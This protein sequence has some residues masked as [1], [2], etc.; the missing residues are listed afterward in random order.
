MRIDYLHTVKNLNSRS[1]VFAIANLN[2]KILKN[3]AHLVFVSTTLLNLQFKTVC[4][5]H[6]SEQ[7]NRTDRH[8]ITKKFLSIIFEYRTTLHQP[9]I[10]SLLL[11]CAIIH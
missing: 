11:T 3:H 1:L 7:L 10:T 6:I 4:F 8:I 2:Q 9:Q 5:L